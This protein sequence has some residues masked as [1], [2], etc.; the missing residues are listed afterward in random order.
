MSNATFIDCPITLNH[1]SSPS[2]LIT[3][4]IVKLTGTEALGELFHFDVELVCQPQHEEEVFELLG[5]SA[6]IRLPKTG[7]ASQ[8]VRTIKGMVSEVAYVGPDH[9]LERY[10]LE[11]VPHVWPLSQNLRCQIFQQKSIEEILQKLF[12]GHKAEFNLYET[13]SRRNYTVQYNESDFAFACRLMEEHGIYFYFTNPAHD[14]SDTETLVVTDSILSNP[15]VDGKLHFDNRS[16]PDGKDNTVSRWQVSRRLFPHQFAVADHQFQLTSPTLEE[17]SSVTESRIRDLVAASRNTAATGNSTTAAMTRS[18]FS[19][20]V[21][22]QYDTID[23]NGTEVP[24]ALSGISEQET[25]A[26]KIQ[27]ERSMAANTL[28]VEGASDCRLMAAASLFTLPGHAEGQYLLTRVEHHVE[29]SPAVTAE[30]ASDPFGQIYRNRFEC[31]PD[32]IP[33]RPAVRTPRPIVHGAHTAAVIGPT[34]SEIHTDKFGR[35]KVRFLWNGHNESNTLDSCW[36]RVANSWAGNNWG[37]LSLPRVG[38]EVVV[39]FLGGDPDCPLVTGSVYNTQHLPAVSLPTQCN[40]SVWKSK[41][42]GSSGSSEFCGIGIDDTAS[43]ECLEIHSQRDAIV[44]VNNDLYENI[45]GW[46]FSNI[47]WGARRQIGGM[48]DHQE[49]ISPFGWGTTVKGRPA[50]D[51]DYVVG[52]RNTSTLGMSRNFTHGDTREVVLN[53]MG[54][55]ASPDF[56][57]PETRLGPIGAV[58]SL[59][60]GKVM[61]TTGS[62]LN[63]VAGTSMNIHRGNCVSGDFDLASWFHKDKLYWFFQLVRHLRAAYFL[64]SL[65]S[66]IIDL[67]RNIIVQD[68]SN[69]DKITNTADWAFDVAD[70]VASEIVLHLWAIFEYDAATTSVSTDWCIMINQA[71][72][73]LASN[74]DTESAEHYS[75]VLER[76]RSRLGKSPAEDPVNPNDG[77]ST[78]SHVHSTT[79]VYGI[80]SCGVH[81][82]SYPHIDP[83]TEQVDQPGSVTFECLGTDEKAAPFTVNSSDAVYLLGGNEASF[84]LETKDAKGKAVLSCGTEGTLT[85]QSG[86][87]DPPNQL[88]FTSEGITV[89]SK[90]NTTITVGNYSI[91]VSDSQV[92]IKQGESNEITFTEQSITLALGNTSVKLEETG[93][94]LTGT[95]L[96]FNGQQV[97]VQN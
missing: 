59:T 91:A 17:K 18:E 83:V 24:T 92:Q 19:L 68:E 50:I 54:Y 44:S 29:Q 38:Q 64:D 37:T 57:V 76:V 55:L 66:Q 7:D 30:L 45:A 89:N 67:N 85:L 96:K 15:S 65:I 94:T 69:S 22:K 58:T 78:Q 53:F 36:I 86:K 40:Q 33:Y 95:Q 23:S 21:S 79:G 42:V 32:N 26:S 90:K 60:S 82:S 10:H 88:Q 3:F 77:S 49:G 48:D 52:L 61:A 9:G 72:K 47:E 13:Y 81:F 39:E 80:R 87:E 97:A 11:L 51:S 62:H 73:R 28:R 31:I 63:L 35:I 5:H 56:T 2:D 6:S 84:S 4:P 14:S 43:K 46:Q 74:I 75:K 93:I 16:V 8:S 25:R 70:T 34:G 20:G 27:L 41:T 71:M 1:R 12:K